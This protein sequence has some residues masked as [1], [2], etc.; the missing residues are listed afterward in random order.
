MVGL[1]AGWLADLSGRMLVDRMVDHLVDHWDGWKVGLWVAL[2]VASME[3][4]MVG[5]LVGVL[6]VWKEL[7]KVESLAA[8]M[9]VEMVAWRAGL[10]DDW[11]AV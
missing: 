7:Q 1:M 5:L 11:W 8:L 3:I 4:L 6:V 2:T 9:V 10:K